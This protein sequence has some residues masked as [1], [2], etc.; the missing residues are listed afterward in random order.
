VP[1]DGVRVAFGG[2]GRGVAGFRRTHAEAMQAARVAALAG[3]SATAVTSYQR[4]ELVSL[5]AGD[6]SRARRSS[7]RSSARSRRHPSPRSGCARP[8][9]RSSS[10]GAAAPRA[11]KEL[12][13]HQNTV[14]DRVKWAEELMGRRV[15]HNPVDGGSTRTRSTAGHPQAGRTGVRAHAGRR[16]WSRRAGQRGRLS[17]S[18]T[19]AL[20]ER[21]QRAAEL[22]RLRH[23]PRRRASVGSDVRTNN[24]D[25]EHRCPPPRS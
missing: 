11:A 13:V 3:D 24:R 1:P 6:L 22:R 10:P 9:S 4:V 16:P 18:Q 17:L 15:N 14:T 7:R 25:E 2:S 23:G 21:S 12:Y 5:L 8:F 19:S 20:W